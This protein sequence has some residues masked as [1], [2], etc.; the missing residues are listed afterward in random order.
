MDQ[1]QLQQRQAQQLQRAVQQLPPEVCPVCT[2]TVFTQI[3]SL[4]KMPAV[5][6]PT[7]Q[8]GLAVAQAGYLC[9]HCNWK[10]NAEGIVPEDIT[11]LDGVQPKATES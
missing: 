7:G 8:E 10:W 2:S 11:R 5:M 1:Q 6:S 3:V 4:R 9:S